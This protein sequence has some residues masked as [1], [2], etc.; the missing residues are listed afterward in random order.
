MDAKALADRVV[1]WRD[2]LGYEGMYQVSNCGLVRS[3]DRT[4]RAGR[5][6]AGKELKL[7]SHPGGYRVVTLSRN[8]I[9]YMA[10]VHKLVL[11]TFVCARPD[12]ME[13]RHID[14]N[15]ANNKLTNIC[16]ATHIEN[17]ADRKIHGTDTRGQTNGMAKLCE[18]DVWLIRRCATTQEKIANFFGISQQQVS[19]IKRGEHWRQEN[20]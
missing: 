4:D 9:R 13:A 15:P 1:V 8:G 11:E 2:I 14:G 7:C 3:L 16:W 18:L 10:T 19:R 6:L 17:V 20:V 5:K 12:G